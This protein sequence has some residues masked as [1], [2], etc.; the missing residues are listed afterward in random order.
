[1]SA[2]MRILIKFI[3]FIILL[4]IIFK[5]IDLRFLKESDYIFL[6]QGL[7]ITIQ[8]TFCGVLLGVVLGVLLAFLRYL[9]NPIVDIIIEEYVDILRGIPVTIQLLIFAYF[10]LNGVIQSK[11]LIAVIG[12][13]IN[14]SAYVSEIIRSGIESL[15]KGQMEAA[16]ALG[17]PYPMAMIQIIIPQAVRN[18]LPALVNEFI[19]L[20]K[21]TSVVGLV[22]INMFDLTFASKALQSKYYKP[23]PYILAGVIYY[24]CVKLF[25]IFAGTLERK[26]KK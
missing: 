23:E 10:I 8:I 6:L 26:L 5:I 4:T 3:I 21:E 18:I 15:D 22:L 20:F 2:K 13:G 16:R 19:A 1:M 9:K 25:S 7:W 12:F 14:S 17:M 11:F 24:I